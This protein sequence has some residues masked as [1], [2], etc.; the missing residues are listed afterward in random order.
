M[1]TPICDFVREYNRREALRLHMPGHKGVPGL[2]MEPWDIT[3]IDG[4]DSLYEAE[5]IIRRS[6]ENAGSLFGCDTFYST[7]GS[8]QCIRAMLYLAMLHGKNRGRKPLIAAARNVHKTF[9]S[10]AALLDLDVLWLMPEKGDSYLSWN[11]TPEEV[12]RVLRAAPERPAAVYL[13][14]PDYLGG[15]ADIAGIARVCHDLGCLLIVDCAHGAYLRF[16]PQSAHP[17][18]LGADLCCASAHKTLPVLTGGAYLHI[19][20]SLSQELSGSAKAALALFGSTSPS[21]LIL[22]S[23]DRANRYLEGFPEALAG[24]LPQA[25]ELRQKL[26]EKGYCLYGVEPLKLTIYPKPAG[27]TGRE[28]AGE[29]EKRNIVPEFSDPDYLVLM[30]TPE[31]G[32]AGLRRLEEALLEIPFREP[33]ASRPPKPGRG[34]RVKSIR[35]AM[36]A[37]AQLLPV[38]ECLDKI[39]GE[40]SV[41]CP[42]AVPIVVSGER[43]DEAAIACFRYYGVEHCRVLR[44]ES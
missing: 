19:A 26:R 34:E 16:L 9:L 37:P 41:G 31:I 29:L 28:L 13:T 18:D 15:M 25:E 36:L 40:A 12:D 4:A 32:A 17:M 11:M 38:S 30:L 43:I 1:D 27:Y 2:G 3:E 21:Y 39:W 8:S 42:P 20:A 35:E 10:A 14:S 44:E 7:E 22:Q 33:I 6:E 5:G 23:L 24:F